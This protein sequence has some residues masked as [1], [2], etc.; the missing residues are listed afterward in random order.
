MNLNK[1]SIA[2]LL[3]TS[4]FSTSILASG[5]SGELHF[6]GQVVNSPCNIESESTKQ[7]VPFGQLSR[8]S[9][10]AGNFAEKNIAI[11]LK[12]CNFDEFSKDVDGKWVAVKDIKITFGGKNYAGANKEFLGVSGTA[13]NIGIQIKD[14]KFDEAKS[15]L[16]QI[17]N[18][19]GENVL[20]FTAL[21][22]RID[23]A[24]PV[25]EGDF[26]SIADFKITYE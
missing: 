7:E 6:S 10:E 19:Q 2:V 15:I 5:N 3:S 25:T 20:E 21:A 8:A 22:K 4:A 26:N 1:L 9:L 12:E 16:S 23:A 14:F 11:K 24:T 17:R 18:R 13:S